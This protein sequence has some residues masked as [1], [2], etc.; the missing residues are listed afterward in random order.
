MIVYK[1][2]LSG[3]EMISDS[4]K[5]ESKGD[6]VMWE[7]QG[8]FVT[9]GVTEVNIGQNASAEGGEDDEGVNDEVQKVV[10]IIDAFRL[11]ETNFTK[12]DFTTWLKN[13]M[14][15]VKAYLEKS[16]PDRVEGFQKGMQDYVKT[17]LSNF[18]NYQF[19]MGVSCDPEA[20]LALAYYPDGES[21]PKFL[22]FVDGLKG[23]KL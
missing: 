8:K 5:L 2:V 16:K 17:L 15:K 19:F 14:K 18:D 13:Y 20:G 12:K 23:E 9:V 21:N 1:D 22:F 6:G 4:Y 11:Q 10:D 3:D 7:V